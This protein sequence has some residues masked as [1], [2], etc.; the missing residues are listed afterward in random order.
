MSEGKDKSFLINF[1][2]RLKYLRKSRKL[3][4]RKLGL[5]CDVDFADIKKMEDGKINITLLTLENL[6]KGLTVEPKELLDF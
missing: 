4:Y 2:I 3:S 5:L 1:G 6:S